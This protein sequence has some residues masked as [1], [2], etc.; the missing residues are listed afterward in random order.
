MPN[1]IDA[2]HTKRSG[3]NKDGL[4]R[5]NG[6]L[7]QQRVKCQKQNSLRRKRHGPVSHHAHINTRSTF[8]PVQMLVSQGCV[9]SLTTLASSSIW[10]AVSQVQR[11]AW[12][13]RAMQYFAMP[14]GVRHFLQRSVSFSPMAGSS[15]RPR[16]SQLADSD[17]PW[18]FT[19]DS[20]SSNSL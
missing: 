6:F 2:N 17:R 1:N 11:F 10:H 4:Q 20:S 7:R 19:M 9:G 8:S 13:M 5:S 12:Q 3:A 15:S 18:R 16:F 14:L